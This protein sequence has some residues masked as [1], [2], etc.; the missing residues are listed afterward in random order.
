MD[1]GCA[2]MVPK[3]LSARPRHEPTT[4]RGPGLSNH[5]LRSLPPCGTGTRPEASS[6]IVLATQVPDPDEGLQIALRLQ[7][8][9]CVERPKHAKSAAQLAMLRVD[10]TR[11]PGR[12]RPSVIALLNQ[13]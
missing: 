10:G 2:A 6:G 3:A 5:P 4:L 12:N 8:L 13:S 7:L 9:V 11:W 1:P